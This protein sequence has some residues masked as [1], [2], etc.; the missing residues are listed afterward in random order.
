MLRRLPAAS[1]APAPRCDV[2]SISLD[3]GDAVGIKL[4]PGGNPGD[5]AVREPNEV[6]VHVCEALPHVLRQLQVQLLRVLQPSVFI[7][8]MPSERRYCLK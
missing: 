3:V 6:G 2:N 7:L 4:P 5:H 8:F 1:C